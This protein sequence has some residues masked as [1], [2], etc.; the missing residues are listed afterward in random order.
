MNLTH[1][2]GTQEKRAYLITGQIPPQV[3]PQGDAMASEGGGGKEVPSEETGTR[4]DGVARP[5]AW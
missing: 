3:M 5:R 4:G 2:P 1:V